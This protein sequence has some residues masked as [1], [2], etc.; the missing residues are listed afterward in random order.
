ME[1]RTSEAF[2]SC[3]V[4]SRN[5]RWKKL[6]EEQKAIV[7][8]KNRLRV[9]QKRANLSPQE[10]MR[11]LQIE[12]G[13]AASRRLVESTVTKEHRKERERLRAAM[14]RKSETPEQRQQRLKI[15]R[16]KA[17]ERRRNESPASRERRLK[18]GRE[19]VALQ[20]S[21]QKSGRNSYLNSGLEEAYLGNVNSSLLGTSLDAN[22]AAFLSSS[23]AEYW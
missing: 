9:A 3:D 12:R 1:D 10:K 19:R 21:L 14:R 8:E 17:N 15:G 13:K 7:R 2:Q 22:S 11:R 20:R 4:G 23:A 6:S 18:A 5:S 16:E